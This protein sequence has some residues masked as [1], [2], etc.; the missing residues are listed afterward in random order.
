VV[1]LEGR[2]LLSFLPPLGNDV[3]G[4]RPLAVARLAA[5]VPPDLA[6][7]GPGLNVG[8]AADHTMA[9]AG[10]PLAGLPELTGDGSPDPRQ[11]LTEWSA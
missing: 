1:E 10:R 11:L 5:L 2:N 8:A 4:I 3:G 9:W 6:N 7:A